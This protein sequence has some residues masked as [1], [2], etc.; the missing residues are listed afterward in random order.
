VPILP[1]KEVI[2]DAPQLLGIDAFNETGF[3]VRLWIQTQPLKQWDVE[4]EL[5]RRLKL[6]LDDQGI[7]I[8]I[9]QQ[10]VWVRNAEHNGEQVYVWEND[11]Y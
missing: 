3:V 4:R 11:G 6:A 2:L 10:E 9:P 7:S 5:R 1:R 8:G